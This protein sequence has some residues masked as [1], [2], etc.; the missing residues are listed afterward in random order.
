MLSRGL[1]TVLLLGWSVASAQTASTKVLVATGKEVH[2]QNL[3]PG[4]WV[5]EGGERTTSGPPCSATTKRIYLGGM[6]NKLVYQEVKGSAADLLGGENITVVYG[7]FDSSFVGQM[8]GYF[9]WTVPGAQGKWQG[10]F[11]AVADQLKG[12]VINRAVGY[13]MGG[14]L[15]GQKLELYTVS[16]EGTATFVAQVTTK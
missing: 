15:E 12:L 10:T 13:G 4:T 5:C 6:S 8:F 2:T 1:V 9:E 14:R 3:S 11:T 16:A 7:I